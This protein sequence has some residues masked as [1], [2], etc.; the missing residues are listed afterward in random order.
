[1]YLPGSPADVVTNLIFCSRTK[2]II[3]SSRRNIKGKLTPKGLLVSLDIFK[4]SA[5]QLSVSPE[6]VS[7]IPKPPAL[8]T[9]DAN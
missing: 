6:E 5:L 2:S 9:A 4:I 7:M 3:L 8:D 1:M